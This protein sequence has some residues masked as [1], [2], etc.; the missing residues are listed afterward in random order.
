M[1]SYLITFIG[2]MATAGLILLA[3]C[4]LAA[5]KLREEALLNLRSPRH[6]S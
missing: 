1:L 4:T 5:S 3:W 6:K 2:G